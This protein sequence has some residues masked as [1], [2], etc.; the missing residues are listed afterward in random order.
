[1]VLLSKVEK[2][3]EEIMEIMQSLSII[4]VCFFWGGGETTKTINILVFSET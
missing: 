1:M 3:S 4:Q 2:S